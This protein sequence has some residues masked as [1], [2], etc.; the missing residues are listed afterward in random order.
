MN[1]DSDIIRR[2]LERP[3]AFGELFDRHAQ[4]VAA[5]ALGRVGAPA[6]DDILSETFLVA[7]RRRASYEFERASAKPWLFGIA[8]KLVH[9]H[10][11]VEARQWRAWESAAGAALLTTSFESE[12]AGRRIDATERLREIA[13]II[14]R[15][16]VKDRDT[17][18]LLAWADLG[19]EEIAAA[20][21]VPVGTVRSRLHRVRR[22]LGEHLA[23]VLNLESNGVEERHG[24]VQR[25]A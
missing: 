23:D 4:A 24:L 12:D 8:T 5:Y 22:I 20:M 25:T 16:S 7:F 19:Y 14:E 1:S 15:L 11:V 18:L 3:E 21:N 2:S 9:K 17:L 10:R 13:P 6:A